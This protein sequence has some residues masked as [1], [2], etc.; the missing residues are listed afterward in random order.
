[1]RRDVYDTYWRF[2]AERQAIFHRRARGQEAPWTE[3]PILARFKFCNAYRASDRVSQYLIQ[4]VIYGPYG[5][6]LA[7]ED[8]FLRVVLFRLFSKETTWNELEHTT[9]GIRRTTLD[10]SLLGDVLEAL[11]RRQPIYTAAFILC[12]HNTYG[13]RA[14][15][16]NHLALVADMFGQGQLG[17]QL[18]RARSLQAV[19]EALLEWPS[20]GPFLAY[21]IAIDLNY[22]PLMHFSEDD[23]TTPGPGAERGL[24]KVFSDFGSYKPRDLILRM[25]DRQKDEFDRLGLDFED[26]FGRKLHAIDCQGLF[27]ETDKYSRVRFPE[28][29]SNRVRIKQEYRSVH[30]PLLLRYPP[31]W[32]LRDV[33]AGVDAAAMSRLAPTQLTLDKRQFCPVPSGSAAQNTLARR[34]SDDVG[35]TALGA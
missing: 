25:V 1:M 8:V 11:R 34:H 19:Y 10:P 9:N 28:L 33:P 3:D 13:H 16:R 2:A 27:C 5:R 15:H 22:T 12:A 31:K 32:E 20:I 18:A 26:L 24:Q 14:K 6:D 30:A 21:Q 23:F 4:R 29:R 17:R 7:P 35:Q